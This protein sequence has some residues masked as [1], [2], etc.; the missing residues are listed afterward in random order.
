MSSTDSKTANIQK[1]F[2]N[3]TLVAPVLNKASDELNRSVAALDEAL[4][5]LNIGLTVWVTF[6][7]RGV[8]DEEFD[9]DQIGYSKLEG[10]WGIAIRRV[11]G[12]YNT[13]RFG[14]EGP[15]FF[16]DSPRELRLLAVDQI[17]QLIEAL[18]NEALKTTEKVQEKTKQVRELATAIEQITKPPQKKPFDDRAAIEAAKNN[19]PISAKLAEAAIRAAKA[20]T[21]SEA[22][23]QTKEGGK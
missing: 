16:N 22:M 11:W 8:E 10:K 5:K 3:L 17:P 14:D 13:E 2:Q 6:R 21:P 4:R 12:N 9:S 15:W 23:A 19:L 1:H 7:N 18:S 20:I